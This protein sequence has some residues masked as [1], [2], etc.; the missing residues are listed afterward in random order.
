MSMKKMDEQNEEIA[1]MLTT[2]TETAWNEIT[3][4]WYQNCSSQFK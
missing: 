3:G 1:K 4:N 2:G